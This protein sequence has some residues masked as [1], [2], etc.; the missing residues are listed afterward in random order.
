MPAVTPHLRFPL[1]QV[2]RIELLLD[3]LQP[4]IPRNIYDSVIKFPGI[5]QL[6]EIL[7]E[8]KL[9]R[10]KAGVDGIAQCSEMSQAIKNVS[11]F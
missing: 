6:M 10:A 2:E 11:V 9:A 5:A 1:I 4:P 8:R 3:C 7:K